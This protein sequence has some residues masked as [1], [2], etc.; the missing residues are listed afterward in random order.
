MRHFLLASLI[1]LLIPAVQAADKP[2][3]AAVPLSPINCD[4]LNE[5]TLICVRNAT[6]ETI[7]KIECSGFWGTSPLSIARGTIK[8]GE[9][10]IVNFTAGKC[11]KL[12][13]VFTRDGHQYPFAG[14]DTTHN[15][16]LLVDPD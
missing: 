7:T 12:L 4:A 2:V 15:T 3:R 11:N 6:P 13:T 14:F 5:G 9:T 8:S 1:A 16:V 10:T